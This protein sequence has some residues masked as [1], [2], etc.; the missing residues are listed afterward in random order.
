MKKNYSNPKFKLVLLDSNDLI[1]TSDPVG[2]SDLSM[3]GIT[4]GSDVAG[5]KRRDNNIWDE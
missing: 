2:E 3:G 4:T 5:A 1:C